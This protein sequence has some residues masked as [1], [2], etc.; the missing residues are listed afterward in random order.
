M[1][2]SIPSHPKILQLGKLGNILDGSIVVE[3]KIDGSQFAFGRAADDGRLVF[4]SKGKELFVENVDKLFGNTV[5]AVVSRADKIAAAISPGVTLYGEALHAKR[6]NTLEYGR[7]P[8][9]N[10]VL[11]GGTEVDGTWMTRGRLEA[12]AEELA[13]DITPVLFAA[14]CDEHNA[15]QIREHIGTLVDGDSYLGGKRE[16]VVIKNYGQLVHYNGVMSP[17]FQK[18]VSDS[19]KETHNSNWK[20]GRDH[21]AELLDGYRTEARWEKAIQRMREDGRLTGTPKDIGPLVRSVQDD[22]VA[23]ELD[24]L[25]RKLAQHYLP[26]VK[27]IAVRGLPEHY[28]AMLVDEAV[29]A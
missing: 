27:R 10:L 24:E 22:V 9:G 13:F 4:R 18:L 16:G 2:P 20:P 21:L 26:E 29:P 14:D 8:H 5:A 17:M 23:E 1:T 6:H 25:G 12:L 15:R 3:E 28:K 7:A 19:F 11:F